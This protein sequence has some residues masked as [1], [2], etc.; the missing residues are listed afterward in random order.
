M[1]DVRRLMTVKPQA[2]ELREV[3]GG[4]WATLLRERRAITQ[5]L[6]IPLLGSAALLLLLDGLSREPYH[7]VLWQLALVLP[8]SAPAVACHRIVLE[9]D[10]VLSWSLQWRSIEGRF[11]LAAVAVAA[12]GF[13]PVSLARMT[14]P[15]SLPITAA[16]LL[17]G[18]IAGS[19]AIGRISLIFPSLALG[20]ELSF[21]LAWRRSRGSG[22]KMAFLGGVAGLVAFLL[23]LPL[24]LALG[25]LGQMPGPAFAL[26][27][28]VRVAGAAYMFVAVEA[29]ALSHTFRQ[30]GYAPPSSRPA[31]GIRTPRSR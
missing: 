23:F 28:A 20:G 21:S 8:A 7:T 19:Y 16:V 1:R 31:S 22:W 11:V 3:V 12:I 17:I 25:F 26:A 4:T 29:V 5:A 14:A 18:A 9:P 10:R 13:A 30:M 6:A 15:L 2:L 27:E 24:D